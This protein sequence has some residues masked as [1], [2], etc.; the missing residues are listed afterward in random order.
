VPEAWR[1]YLLVLVG[2]SALYGAILWFSAADELSGRPFWILG[3]TA[4]VVAS[5]V[6]GVPEASLAWGLACIFSGGLI[7]LLSARHRKLLPLP[8]F[9]LL[10][11]IGLP[12]TPGWTGMRL[13][14]SLPRV[15]LIPV[16]VLAHA[17]LVAG[18]IRHAIRPEPMP[19]RSQRWLWLLYP[20]GLA[21]FPVLQT[22]LFTGFAW[23]WQ[24][25]PQQGNPV[26]PIIT[27]EYTNLSLLAWAGGAIALGLAALLLWLRYWRRPK[28]K[29]HPLLPRGWIS[30]GQRFFS[31]RWFYDLIGIFM[32]FSVRSIRL[33]TAVL[34]GEGGILWVLVLL[35]LL[36]ALLLRGGQL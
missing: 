9:G 11:F 10:G 23:S 35:A 19:E 21:L 29:L 17:L 27:Q 34:E 26:S 30:F 28:V 4:F 32:R 1:P 12:F 8:L 16:F 13:Y 31:L 5:A 36:V 24:I 15:L 7:F 25:I 6:C 20:L 14:A 18:Y 3:M 2:L 33:L 22:A